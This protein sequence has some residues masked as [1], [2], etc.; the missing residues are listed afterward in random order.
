MAVTEGLRRHVAFT[1]S[2][3]RPQLRPFHGGLPSTSINDR[4]MDAVF[5]QPRLRQMP[6]DA[7]SQRQADDSD[8]VFVAFGMKFSPI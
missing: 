3:C 5:R 4:Y 2:A 6:A 1:A 7:G 8:F